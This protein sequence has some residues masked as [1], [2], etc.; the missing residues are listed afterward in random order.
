MVS[1][2]CTFSVWASS[3]AKCTYLT[4]CLLPDWF[5][6][7]RKVDTWLLQWKCMQ[8]KE[9]SS[10]LALSPPLSACP[11][12]WAGL[13]GLKERREGV[14]GSLLPRRQGN[15]FFS[16]CNIRRRGPLSSFIH[17]SCV[18]YLG[19]HGR[20]VS[21]LVPLPLNNLVPQCQDF[22]LII[23]WMSDCKAVIFILRTLVTHLLP[24]IN[25]PLLAA[26]FSHS[27]LTFHE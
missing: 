19:L 17:T 24:L 8:T 10:L 2:I 20:L 12:V 11:A 9:V 25:G 22:S 21:H 5:C 7:L 26:L 13:Q 15:W 1:R 14:Q 4:V 27:L 3:H 23:E 6:L 16:F 18:N